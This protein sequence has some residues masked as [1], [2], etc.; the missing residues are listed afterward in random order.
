MEQRAV[1]RF[2]TLKDLKDLKVKDIQ[3][4]LEQVYENGEIEIKAIEN[5]D[6]ISYKAN[7]FSR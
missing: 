1:M 6:D 7:R 3:T 2:L 4:V 5:G